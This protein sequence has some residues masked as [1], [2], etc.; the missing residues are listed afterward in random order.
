MTVKI[1]NIQEHDPEVM[2]IVTHMRKTITVEID[3]SYEDMQIEIYY[4]NEDNNNDLQHILVKYDGITEKINRPNLNYDISVAIHELTD[5]ILLQKF[6]NWPN[7]TRNLFLDKI[8]NRIIE[9]MEK[10]QIQWY[11]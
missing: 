1:E 5:C 3:G 4:E 11:C 10:Y 9:T 7:I 8:T 2:A 6:D